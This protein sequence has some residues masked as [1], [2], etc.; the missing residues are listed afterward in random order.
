MRLIIHVSSSDGILLL[1]VSILW[2]WESL[3]DTQIWFPVFSDYV[4]HC[5]GKSGNRNSVLTI[6]AC[7]FHA[8]MIQFLPFPVAWQV[9]ML[10]LLLISTG[11]CFFH[12]FFRSLILYWGSGRWAY[13]W[14]LLW[15][16]GNNSNSRLA[17]GEAA[18]YLLKATFFPLN[19]PQAEGHTA[20]NVRKHGACQT[21]TEIGVPGRKAALAW[22]MSLQSLMVLSN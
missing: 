16:I 10:V 19:H 15:R 13:G 2:V 18:F 9:F 21:F 11:S 7:G 20:R 14:S 3:G 4:G 8:F 5:V 1:L 6:A 12:F 22:G 17:G